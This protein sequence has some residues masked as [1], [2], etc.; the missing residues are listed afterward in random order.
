V[1]DG[2]G[3]DA[4]AQFLK[5]ELHGYIRRSLDAQSDWSNAETT[6]NAALRDACLTCD[7]AFLATNPANRAGS[8]ACILLVFGQSIMSCANVG[9]SRCCLATATECV[10]LSEDQT[11]ARADEAQRIRDAG[12]FVIHKRVMGELAV[13]R[14]FGDAE[15]KRPVH[16]LVRPNEP[17]PAEAGPR[18]VLAEPEVTHRAVEGEFALIA[19]DGLYDVFSSEEAVDVVRKG[20]VENAGDPVRAAASV[21]SAAVDDRGSRDNVTAVVVALRAAAPEGVS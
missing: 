16:E 14:A 17:A 8:T 4:C 18:M 6:I 12:G 11:P 2:H 1:Y 13:S 5:D 20:L 3:G 7:A 9:D 21:C 10:Q 19:C 15:L